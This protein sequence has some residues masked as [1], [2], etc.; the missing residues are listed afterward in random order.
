MQNRKFKKQ[1]FGFFSQLSFGAS[2]LPMSGRIILLMTVVLF[3]SLFFPWIH[4]QT[5]TQGVTTYSAFSQ[6]VGFVG[7][8]IIV[9]VAVIFFFLLSHTKKEQVRSY[10][11]FRLSDTQAVVFVATMILV[12]TMQILL[13]LPAFTT[14]GS[15]RV[16]TG[17]QLAGASVVIILICGFFLSQNIKNEKMEAYYLDHNL[18]ED[19]W[20]YTNIIR[21]DA[22]AEN[23]RKKHNMTL[24]F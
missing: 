4:I 14:I 20:E 16:D 3:S 1:I 10:M 18:E 24:P 6:Y 13:I 15:V 2:N 21:T 9:G 22:H 23:E 17:M 5:Q 19:F 8:G 7:Y 11:P 12:T